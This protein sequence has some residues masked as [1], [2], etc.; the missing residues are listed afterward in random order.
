MHDTEHLSPCAS[1]LLLGSVLQG[2]S[3]TYRGDVTR[4]V[5]EHVKPS[6]AMVLLHMYV[7]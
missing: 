4:A 7:L 6:A 5:Y 2:Y 3:A 1:M